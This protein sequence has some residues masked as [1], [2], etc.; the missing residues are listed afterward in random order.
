MPAIFF[1]RCV[2]RFSVLMIA[3]ANT[4]C[5]TVRESSLP[6]LA[7]VESIY[8]LGSMDIPDQP[9]QPGQSGVADGDG[10]RDRPRTELW[11]NGKKVALPG[12]SPA[13]YADLQTEVPLLLTQLYLTVD[14]QTWMSRYHHVQQFWDGGF[15]L[16]SGKI[17]AWQL[18]PGG[19]GR[20]E[21]NY[22]PE[23]EK[24]TRWIPGTAAPAP[25]RLFVYRARHRE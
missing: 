7:D 2:W 19:L 23:T 10:L 14:Y 6:T 22:D 1:K 16:R 8:V 15:V 25:T 21:L 13:D 12:A 18:K 20:V 4:A 11:R 3:L 17:M 5:Q 24:T 9:A